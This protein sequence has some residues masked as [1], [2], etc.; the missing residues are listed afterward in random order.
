ML[1][2]GTCRR[3][4]GAEYLDLSFAEDAED[5]AALRRIRADRWRRGA[6]FVAVLVC[7][8]ATQAVVYDGD[9]LGV[10]VLYDG[11]PALWM[12]AVG[13][14]ALASLA[15]LVQDFSSLFGR[16]PKSWR[17]EPMSI[18]ASEPVAGAQVGSVEPALSDD[19]PSSTEDGGGTEQAARR[20][21]QRKRQRS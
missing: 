20:A 16:E 9:T 6:G 5:A 2:D 15:L 17:T 4:P 21:A 10:P 19:S 13:L 1:T 7:L 3:H 12:V 14:S 18:E 8:F 11:G